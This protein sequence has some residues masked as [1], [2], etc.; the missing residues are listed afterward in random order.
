M[1]ANVVLAAL[2]HVWTTLEPSGCPRALMGGLSL[3]FWRYVRS[4][5]DVDVLIDPQPAGF[6]RG[7]RTWI[8]T[9]SR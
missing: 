5:Q 1:A 9:S 4:T 3:A 6:Q 7:F 2:K 8:S